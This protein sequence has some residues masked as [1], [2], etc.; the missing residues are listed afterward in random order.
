MSST[1]TERESLIFS[2]F[3]R[4]QALEFKVRKKKQRRAVRS[5]H[6]MNIKANCRS[7]ILASL[8]S[9]IPL[10]AQA[11]HGLH[12][13]QKIEQHQRAQDRHDVLPERPVE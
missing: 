8:V 9:L 7:I 1:R 6:Y 3:R 11:Q 10:A 12:G 13:E 5:S 4:S 2:L